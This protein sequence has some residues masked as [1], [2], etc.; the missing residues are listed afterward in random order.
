MYEGNMLKKLKK[1]IAES[2]FAPLFIE[3]NKYG[4]IV[5][6]IN[7][8]LTKKQKHV[9][10]VYLDMTEAGIQ[11]ASYYSKNENGALHTNR[12]ELFQIIN[13]FI[14]M[15]YCIDVCAH[16]D[17]RALEYIK[18]RQYDVIFGLGDVFHWTVNHKS[19][20]KILYLTEN[21]YDVSHDREKE[22]IDYF[23]ERHNRVL[24][25]ERTGKFFTK[26]EEKRVDAIICLGE[27]EYLRKRGVKVEHVYP[28]AFLNSDFQYDKCKRVKNNFLVFGT[29]GFVHKGI[30]LLI[31]VFN[32]HP[33]WELYLCGS[34]ITKYV[35]NKLHL[36]IKSN[37]IHDC[38]Y[39]NIKSDKFL[40]LIYQC[41]FILQPSCSEA[42]STAVLTGMRHGLIPIVT[43]GNGFEMLGKERCLFFEGFH[44]KDIEFAIKKAVNLPDDYIRTKSK[45]IYQYA[46]KMFTI[47]MFTLNMNCAV[48][49]I[50]EGLTYVNQ[51]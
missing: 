37:N 27:P 47:D 19:A 46:N 3:T 36:T 49:N 26:D 4:N 39:I 6:N 35:K 34:G 16:S 33:E 43:H 20:Y 8:N 44:I 31:E 21:P 7:L 38:G 15:D 48:Q 41:P 51:G 18:M 11:L 23:Y 14:Q 50:C 32:E 40:E 45:D 1:Y 10:L 2:R 9:L 24:P 22:R 5:S 29:D 12:S 42:V 30:D 25:F 13:I 17:K 28:S